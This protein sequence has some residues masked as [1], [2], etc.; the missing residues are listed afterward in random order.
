MK[1]GSCQAFSGGVFVGP[2]RVAVVQMASIVGDARG[3]SAKMRGYVVEAAAHGA[4][5]VCFPEACLTGYSARDAAEIAVSREF[6]AVKTLSADALH[7]GIVVSFGLVEK[8][9]EGTAEEPGQTAKPFVTHIV[10]DGTIRLVYRKTHLGTTEVDAFSAGD[11]QPVAQVAGACVGVQLCWESHFPELSSTL[12]A[13]GAEVL[14]V[15]FASGIGGSRRRESWLRFLPAR[16]NDTGS[17]VIACNA[18]KVAG[19]N[20]VSR[21]TSA[22][23]PD[24]R[25]ISGGGILVLDPRGNIVGEF[26]EPREQ[27]IICDLDATLPRNTPERMGDLSYFDRRRPE[28]YL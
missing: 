7:Q 15:P 21:E 26:F 14:L 16:A 20:G 9:D 18:L 1:P 8:A 24:G 11:E 3:N 10:T 23:E 22:L 2:L 25:L 6:E 27:M 19:G 12:R 5:M 4:Q 13:K 17:Y 28:L